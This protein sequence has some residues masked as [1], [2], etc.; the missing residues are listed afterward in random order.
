MS[1]ICDDSASLCLESPPTQV[2]VKT[3]PLPMVRD[4]PNPSQ[5]VFL[6]ILSQAHSTTTH[7]LTPY[8]PATSH[9]PSYS[10]CSATPKHQLCPSKFTLVLYFPANPRTLSIP[11]AIYVPVSDILQSPSYSTHPGYNAC[12]LKL[13]TWLCPMPTYPETYLRTF[14]GHAF[15]LTYSLRYLSHIPTFTFCPSCSQCCSYR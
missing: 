3:R 7:S 4:T 12:C 9:T 15:Y 10:V 14:F 11:C 8:R 6:T 1:T 13:Q 2:L 5:S